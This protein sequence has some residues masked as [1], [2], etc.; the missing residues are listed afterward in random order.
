MKTLY[1][2]PIVIQL[3]PST[4]LL[5]L[6][7]AVATF[8][9]LILWTLPIILTTKL[10]FIGLVVVSSL[11]FIARDA[12]L[13]LPWSWRRIEVDSKGVLTLTNNRQKRFKPEL[14]TSTFVHEYCVILNLKNQGVNWALS[15]VLLLEHTDNANALRRL[16]VWLRLYKNK[17]AKQTYPQLSQFSTTRLT[18]N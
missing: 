9:S 11:Y 6:L 14:A 1:T 18:T 4:L 7:L 17:R 10:V 16:R 5:G 13:I 3:L 8:S 2:K 15:P 12:L